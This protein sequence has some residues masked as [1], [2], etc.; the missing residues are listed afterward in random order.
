MDRD[1]Q[2]WAVDISAYNLWDGKQGAAALISSCLANSVEEQTKVKRYLREIDQ[3][4]A[5]FLRF[6]MGA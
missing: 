4:R 1:V 5:Y 3:I 6:V 2:V